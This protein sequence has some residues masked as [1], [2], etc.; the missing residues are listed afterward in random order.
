MVMVVAV[1]V[2]IIMILVALMVVG[3]NSNSHSSSTSSSSGSDNNIIVIII[4]PIT[5]SW[6]RLFIR[7]FSPFFFVFFFSLFVFNTYTCTTPQVRFP[8]AQGSSVIWEQILVPY[9]SKFVPRCDS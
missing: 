6:Y 7:D 1:V 3:S 9:P 2:V 4:Y 5:M 8:V